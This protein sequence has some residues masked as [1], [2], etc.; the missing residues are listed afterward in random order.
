M[1]L[2]LRN[3]VIF[4]FL[5][6]L[7]SCPFL[8]LSLSLIACALWYLSPPFYSAQPATGFPISFSP[9]LPS[10]L[11]SSPSL[12]LLR[13]SFFIGSVSG[14]RLCLSCVPSRVHPS[15]THTHTL[16]RALLPQEVEEER[17]KEYGNRV[18]KKRDR[19]KKGEGEWWKT[20]RG[21]H[22]LWVKLYITGTS[23]SLS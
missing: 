6:S 9:F 3:R 5:V 8:S 1:R 20:D 10:S 13:W 11:S 16:A 4:F 21:R 15:N 17:N 7:C 14:R 22:S 18:K 12:S 2:Q 23:V 19:F